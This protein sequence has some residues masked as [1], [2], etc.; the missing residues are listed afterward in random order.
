M[1]RIYII[2]VCERFYEVVVSE[3]SVSKNEI[4]LH[5]WARQIDKVG[6]SQDIQLSTEFEC[7]IIRLQL[8]KHLSFS[9]R[10]GVFGKE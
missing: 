4:H 3:I 6:A 10:S 2:R 5:V 7:F 9:R 1:Y 8:Q